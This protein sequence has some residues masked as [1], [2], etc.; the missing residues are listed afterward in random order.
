LAAT[1]Y[2]HAVPLETQQ[3]TAANGYLQTHLGT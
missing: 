3:W 1:T 2:L